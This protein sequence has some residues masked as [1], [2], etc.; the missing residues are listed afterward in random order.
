MSK[1]LSKA[2]KA[3]GE[4]DTD[5]LKEVLAKAMK[6]HGIDPEPILNPPKAKT[7]S[8]EKFEEGDVAIYNANELPA[9]SQMKAALEAMVYQILPA[10]IKKTLKQLDE[11]V[12]NM[13]AVMSSQDTIMNRQNDIEPEA[14]RK[15][16]ET[17][18]KEAETLKLKVK[19]VI[20]DTDNG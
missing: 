18:L 14:L 13:A 10:E 20:G 16:I 7:L 19:D 8:K 1:D 3:L 17:M 4:F 5:A 9:L 15:Q 6:Q 2:A 12:P 11:I